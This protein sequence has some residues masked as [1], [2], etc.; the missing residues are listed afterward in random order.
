MPWVESA[1]PQELLA[2][3]RMLTDSSTVH[4]QDRGSELHQSSGDDE[5]HSGNKRLESAQLHVRLHRAWA[6]PSDQVRHDSDG[7]VSADAIT[8]RHSTD[9]T[10]SATLANKVT[11]A[12]RQCVGREHRSETGDGGVALA[13]ALRQARHEAEQ[14]GAAAT[15]VCGSLYLVG[16]FLRLAESPSIPATA[17]G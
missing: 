11:E 5:N 14:R 13:A 6:V 12:S 15:V 7:N 3:T 8:N 17:N 10:S 4:V 2:L 16:E 1:S 9:A